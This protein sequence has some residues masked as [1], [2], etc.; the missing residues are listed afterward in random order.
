M[1]YLAIKRLDGVDVTPL[2]NLIKADQVQFIVDAT[3]A[4]ARIEK[5][6]RLAYRRAFERG[7]RDGVSA[8]TAQVAALMTS[9][10]AAAQAYWTKSER[11]MVDIVIEA[12]RRIIGDFDD[13][14]VVAAIVGRL[15]GEARDEGKIR[16]YV[17][18]SC[19]G[20]VENRVRDACRL[21]PDVGAIEVI[22]DAAVDVHACRVESEFGVVET[23]LESQI[24]SLQRAL[25]EYFYAP[26]RARESQ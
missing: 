11:R 6:S 1:S 8:G 17:S 16:L 9:T 21:Y 24:E 4:M 12:V 10:S 7:K 26:A 20:A 19:C 15:I 5:H 25:E 2:D 3:G 18:P 22:G 23:S 13:S 14:E